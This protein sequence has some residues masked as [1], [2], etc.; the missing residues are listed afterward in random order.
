MNQ[1]ADPL[2]LRHLFT[3][4]PASN[5]HF[6]ALRTGVGVLLPLLV[7]IALD[8]L[9]LAPFAIFGAFT[10]V[11]S[12][13]P[14]QL[15]RLLMQLKASL[16]M[17]VMILAA[18]LTGHHLLDPLPEAPR[19]WALVGFTTIIAGLG[20]IAAGLFR[21]RPAGSLFHIFAFAAISSLPGRPGLGEAMFTATAVMIFSLIVGQLGRIN[22]GR[23]TPW[24]VARVEP[25]SREFRR[26]VWREALAYVVAA[27]LAGV[28]AAALS[29]P[30]GRGHVYWAMVAAVVPLVGHT[31]RH[32]IARGI[33][34]V[35]GTIA[36]L[37]LIAIVVAV[38]PPVWAAV[39]LI[40]ITQF[41]AE[42]FIVRNYFLGQMFVTPLALIGTAMGSG[43]AVGVLWD[44]LVETLIG[45]TVGIAVTLVVDRLSSRSASM[46]AG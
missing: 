39:L 28:L 11:Y 15:D 9:D 37:A 46:R 13:V 42:L 27:G 32:R 19:L 43:L 4:G 25:L 29:G 8:R 31:M 23:R 22:P 6:V 24:Q 17:W 18:W 16:V 45:A 10:G 12:R 5:D 36:G 3:L 1:P 21:L 44:R 14:A 41:L 7:L 33:H 20:S 34:R 26:T 30:L 38:Q 40:G 35:L 2:N